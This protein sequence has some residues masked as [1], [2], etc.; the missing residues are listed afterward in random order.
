MPETL[1]VHFLPHL[2]SPD[3]LAGRQVVVIDVLRATTTIC[4]ALAHGAQAVVPCLEIDE[5]RQ[6]AARFAPGQVVLGG[7]RGGLPIDGFDLG[8]APSEY[9][10]DAVGDRT[11]VFTTT[12]GT[13][14]LAL[15]HKAERVLLGALVNLRAVCDQIVGA[16]HVDLLCAGTGGRVT[17]EDVL[18]AGA[19]VERL[20]RD[21]ES[22][23][24]MN[25]PAYLARDA[26]RS[27]EAAAAAH[28][29]SLIERLAVEL[30]ETHG[31][32]NLLGIGHD[33]DLEVAAQIDKFSIVPQFDS[34]RGEIR[35]P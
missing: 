15:C 17:R 1:H 5:A 35:L 16:A 32:R 28:G 31:G 30:R 11:V 33:R 6:R 7:E 9:T 18:A 2:T 14:A 3:E 29:Q 21:V 27:V 10:R 34:Q 12:N 24:K 26:W 23:P 20:T 13:R 4:H 19:M 22:A 25:D 8:N